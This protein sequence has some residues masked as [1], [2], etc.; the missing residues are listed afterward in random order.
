MPEG[1]PLIVI[2]KNVLA[3]LKPRIRVPI[4]LAMRYQHPSIPDAVRRLAQAGVDDL[5]L[6]PLLPHYAM[7]SFETAVVRGK[8][9]AASIAPRMRIR[10]QP[11]FFEPPEYIAAPAA[12]ARDL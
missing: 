5:L 8:G 7:S 4:E 2:S 9:V 12:S 1:S 6:I 11:P 3:K 10:G